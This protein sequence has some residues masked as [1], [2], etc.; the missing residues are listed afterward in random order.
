MY[1]CEKIDFHFWFD[2]VLSGCK[3]TLGAPGQP[4]HQFTGTVEG[5]L[6]LPLLHL[7]PFSL[8]TFP[9][10]CPFRLP[11]ARR[12]FFTFGVNPQ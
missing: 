1:V 6:L 8:V 10:S 3:Q 12:F 11:T 7:P 5:L 9:L 2:A 4:L